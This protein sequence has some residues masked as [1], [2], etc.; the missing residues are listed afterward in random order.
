MTVGGALG[1]RGFLGRI[2]AAPIAGRAMAQEAASLMTRGG[3]QAVGLAV[4][5]AGDGPAQPTS[6]L[7]NS[8]GPQKFFDFAEWFRAAGEARV[9][10]QAKELN[11]FDADLLAMRSLSLVARVN[12]QRERNYARLVT[13]KREYFNRRLSAEGVFEWWP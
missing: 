7:S 10:E 8:K 9:K 1:R 12:I 5:G 2:L 3:L 11:G 13:E 6:S 4:S